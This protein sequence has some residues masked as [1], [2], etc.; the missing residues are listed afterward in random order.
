MKLLL[1]AVIVVSC[2]YTI[3][4]VYISNQYTKKELPK[5]VSDIYDAQRYQNYLSYKAENQRMSMIV[6]VINTCFNI[7]FIF[8]NFYH[9][10]DTLTNNPYMICLYT[11]LIMT[12][13]DSVFSVIF[14][15]YDTFYIEEKYGLNKKD[16]KE[17]IKDEIIDIVFTSFLMIM[18]MVFI[19][20]VCENMTD[21]VDLDNMT[22]FMALL[23]MGGICLAFGVIV[24][25]MNLLAY[26][27]LKIQY[28]FADLEEGP[29]RRDIENMLVG[30]KKKVRRIMVYNESK[31]STT[32]NAF[33]LNLFGYREFGI[34]DN[35]MNE[36]DYRELLAVLA[37]EV[38]HLRH[39]KTIYNYIKY[40][41]GICG[42]FLLVY[43][44]AHVSLLEN[45]SLI[46]MQTF[47]IS[48]I[49]YYLI[50]FVIS[51]LLQPII[52]LFNVY[53][54]YA[55]RIE[56]YEA[57][58]HSVSLGYGKE[59]IHTFKELSKDELVNV[60]PSPIIEF[61]E[62]D[63]PG[64]YHRIKAIEEGMEKSA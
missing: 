5:E 56:E 39:K 57:D 19:V 22:Y 23:V 64:M 35:F 40:V 38:G 25:I 49:N 50:I 9:W 36:N 62:Y 14:H 7:F 17:F 31:K 45:L 24:V 33:L 28:H 18:I 37:H 51:T 29:L 12:I 53:N 63:H 2:L 1:L 15:Y 41:M 52:F 46:V 55:T 26:V 54:N 44:L 4:K 61:L 21:W 3:M 47:N 11:F 30:C 10:I 59:L 16:L 43:L 8:S 27:V 48:T 6:L 13:I 60:N 20:F 34:A 32:K 58:R 42:F